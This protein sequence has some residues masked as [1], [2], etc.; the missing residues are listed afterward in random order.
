M[1]WRPSSSPD[2]ST[3]STASSLPRRCGQDRQDQGVR[4]VEKRYGVRGVRIDSRVRIVEK[5]STPLKAGPEFNDSDPLKRTTGPGMRGP[6]GRSGYLVQWYRVRGGGYFVAS[7]AP[8][9][10]CSPAYD[11]F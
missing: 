9:S 1:A 7:A 8:F 3:R 11:A 10:A 6:S 2:G 4:V 5:R